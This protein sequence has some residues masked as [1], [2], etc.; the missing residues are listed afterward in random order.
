MLVLLV[1]IPLWG[2]KKKK[3]ADVALSSGTRSREAEFYF[4]E[5]EK[6]FI[7]EDYSKA[8]SYYQR[9]LELTP[10]NATVH[11]KIAEVLVQSNRPEDLQK[12]AISIE[13]AMRLEK[14]NKYFYL[15]AAN[16]YSSLTR[17][18]RA[19]QI[20]ET[21]LQEV[22]G[23]EE[24]LY[25]LAAVYQYANKVEEAIKTYQ[26]AESLLG[27][28][29]I[30]SLQKQRLYLESGRMKEAIA[31][32]DKLMAAFPG[33]ERY[34]M[35]FTEV[36]SQKGMRN[37]A[38]QYL[39]KFIAENPEAGNTR[40]LLAGFYRD[41]NEEQKARPL[42]L[43]L[44]DNNDVELNS[45]LIILGAYNAELNI[46]KSKNSI[47]AEKQAF[48]ESL[49]Q[50]IQKNYPDDPNVNIIGGDLYLSTGKNR[51]AQKYYLKAIQ[52]GDVGFEVWENL[53]YLE[54]QLEQYDQL[55]AHSDQALELYPNQGMLHYFNGYGNLRKRNYRE[56][57]ASFEQAK[58]LSATNANLIAELNS[59]LGEAY[60]ATKEFD[61]SDKAYDEAL[62]ASPE[63]PTVLNN[64][65]FYLA[66]R[67]ANLEKAEKMAALLTKNYPDNATFLD[68]YAW[69]LYVK[70]KYKDAKKAMERAI[71]TGKAN[72]THFEHYGDILFK[73]GDIDAAVAQ[74]EKARGLNA[75]SET[76]NRKI[77]NRK[78]YE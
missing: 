26:R 20:Y 11:Y 60:N 30:S 51:D 70:G 31:E 48:A 37:E 63:N 27:I 64:Y 29:E 2:Q 3:A 46:A 14:K 62:L 76:L 56:A 71:G 33:E 34:V 44:F 32:G 41:N 78:I 38:I 5:G 12:A 18:D 43:T 52:S 15:L 66:L 69:V 73:L 8:L 25:E 4:T 61:K 13:N 65:S 57:I 1:S 50:K 28:N 35:A 59:L 9:T 53:L 58:R 40:M 77:A 36:L 49:F 42:L 74:W 23:S 22:K 47:D 45:K 67:K 6:F 39:E 19:A 55:I 75:N 7:L 16:I 10:D 72:A 24:Y 54:N 68:T 17:F 21:L